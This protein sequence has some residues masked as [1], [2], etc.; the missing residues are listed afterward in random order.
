MVNIHVNLGKLGK[1]RGD[2]EKR[3]F[4]EKNHLRRN[5]TYFTNREVKQVSLV[6]PYVFE[7]AYKLDCSLSLVREQ[8]FA[9]I[10]V[11]NARVDL[12]NCKSL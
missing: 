4:E 11:S 5:G 6:I 9:L 8:K 10:R 3:L 1:K 7:T 2:E 12:T